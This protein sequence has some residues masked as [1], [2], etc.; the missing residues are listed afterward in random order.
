MVA[1]RFEPIITVSPAHA[2]AARY[3]ASANSSRV[4]ASVY[5]RRAPHERAALRGFES[6][7]F[8]NSSSAGSV[9]CSNK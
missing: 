7:A 6:S 9:F 8:M 5:A 3:C 1:P 2:T 4:C